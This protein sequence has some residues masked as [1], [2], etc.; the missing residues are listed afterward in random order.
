M[1]TAT[2][3]Q[4]RRLQMTQLASSLQSI[5]TTLKEEVSIQ[6]ALAFSDNELAALLS[7]LL[8]VNLIQVVSVA[9]SMSIPREMFAAALSKD[10]RDIL[11]RAATSSQASTPKQMM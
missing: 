3:L 2:Q 4:Q 7:G 6:D 11:Q 9:Q 5:G 10:L 8:R 1:T